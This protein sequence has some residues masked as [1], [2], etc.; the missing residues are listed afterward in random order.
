M[1]AHISFLGS[2]SSFSLLSRFTSFLDNNNN[3]DAEGVC[4]PNNNRKKERIILAHSQDKHY[5]STCQ[6]NEQAKC[7]KISTRYLTTRKFIRITEGDDNNDIVEMLRDTHT[8]AHAVS[9][10]HALMR[11]TN[12]RAEFK[13]SSRLA[14][15]TSLRSTASSHLPLR[16]SSLFSFRCLSAC[17]TYGCFSSLF[18]FSVYGVPI[19]Y[20]SSF[21]VACCYYCRFLFL[22]D[23]KAAAEWR[24]SYRR[25]STC[26]G[27]RTME[28][29]EKNLSETILLVRQMNDEK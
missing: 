13:D 29:L 3:D 20:R 6:C 22:R 25:R 21:I 15:Y 19:F 28:D 7:S 5:L 24:V 26:M 12:L 2:F 1:W 4:A 10:F 9:H 23:G 8:Y 11:E 27:E 17:V 14:S 18:L 16:L